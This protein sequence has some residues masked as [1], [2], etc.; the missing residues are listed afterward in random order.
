MFSHAHVGPLLMGFKWKRSLFQDSDVSSKSDVTSA[1]DMDEEGGVPVTASNFEAMS[2]ALDA[3]LARD[4]ELD[5][6]ELQLAAQVEADDL[7]GAEDMDADED[8]VDAPDNGAVLLTSEERAEEKRAG[9]PEVHV[10]Q[11]RMRQ[12]LGILKR[13]KTS[14]AKIGRYVFWPRRGDD[15]I[16]SDR[17]RA[18]FVEQLILDIASYYGYNDFLAEKLFQLFPAAEVYP[19]PE[20]VC[21]TDH[22]SRP[23]NFSMQTRFLGPS[24]SGRILSAPDVVTLHKP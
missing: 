9:G 4:A 11:K 13:W 23:L 7:E 16:N 22:I 17:N 12:C 14:G 18:E 3:R 20:T 15:R 6:E 2:R 5:A 10:V 24:P 21:C 8:E 1:S 19:T